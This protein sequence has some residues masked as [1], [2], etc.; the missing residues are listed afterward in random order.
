MS[1][2]ISENTA[3]KLQWVHNNNIK[4]QWVLII[5]FKGKILNTQEMHVRA[6]IDLLKTRRN[7]HLVT[8]IFKRAR[9][10][11]YIDAIKQSYMGRQ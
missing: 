5:I 9:D 4:L 11:E 6:N 3:F 7:V 2:Y 1:D 10:P 8:L